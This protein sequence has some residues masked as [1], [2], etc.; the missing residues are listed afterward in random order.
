VGLV[1]CMIRIHKTFSLKRGFVLLSIFVYIF[2]MIVRKHV[3]SYDAIMG[4]FFRLYFYFYLSMIQ[5][6]L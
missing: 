6:M 1:D 2:K 5:K 4:Y 3:F